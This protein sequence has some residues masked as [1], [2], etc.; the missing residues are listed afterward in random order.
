MFK[1]QRLINRPKKGGVDNVKCQFHAERGS[2]RQAAAANYH[3][4][5]VLASIAELLICTSSGNTSGIRFFRFHSNLTSLVLK[6]ID[7]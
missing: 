5:H 4:I 3:H 6:K 2:K 1:L 7:S